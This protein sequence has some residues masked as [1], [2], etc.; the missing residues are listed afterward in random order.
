VPSW[1]PRLSYEIVI[2]PERIT[3]SDGEVRTAVEPCLWVSE[4]GRIIGV[5]E[6]PADRSGRPI[7]LFAPAPADDTAR[8]DALVKFFRFVISLMQS[9]HVFKLRPYVRVHGVASLRP[10]LN[11]YEQEIVRQALLQSGAAR[12]VFSA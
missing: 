12:V 2:G 4:D 8:F 9:A 5:G 10:L 1:F 7:A 6:R 3:F 11:G